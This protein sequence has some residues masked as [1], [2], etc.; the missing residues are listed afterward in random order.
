MTFLM[1]TV[2]LGKILT[3]NNLRRRNI[4]LVNWCCMCKVDGENIDHLFLHYVQFCAYLGC[5]G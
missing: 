5:I 3:A 4:I 2:A 1:W